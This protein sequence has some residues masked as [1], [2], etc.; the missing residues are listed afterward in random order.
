LLAGEAPYRESPLDLSIFPHAYFYGNGGVK[1]PII[2]QDE[3]INA[4]VTIRRFK[5]RNTRE[6]TIA[7]DRSAYL[8]DF[9]EKSVEVLVFG[10]V[11]FSQAGLHQTPQAKSVVN[12]HD[13][14]TMRALVVLLLRCP[15]RFSKAV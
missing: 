12:T 14:A 2:L 6:V 11:V 3:G 13:T 7:G 4:T 1:V 5:P 9:R 15:K 8:F 10:T